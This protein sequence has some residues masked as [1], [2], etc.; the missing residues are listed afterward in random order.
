VAVGGVPAA[1]FVVALVGSTLLWVAVEG[2]TLRLKGTL[3][4]ATVVVAACGVLLIP[5]TSSSGSSVMAVVQGDV[6]HTR[7]LADMLR[8]TTVTDNHAALTRT[9]AAEVRAG[10]RG[11]PDVVVWPENSTDVDPADS[12]QVYAAIS[13]AVGAV[14][15]PVLVGAVLDAPHD[16]VYNAGQLWLPGRGPVETYVKRTLVPFGEYVPWRSLLAPHINLLSLVPHDFTPGT[17]PVVFP[18]GRTRLGDVICYEIAFDQLVRSDVRAGANVLVEQTNDATYERDGQTGE[19]EQQLQMA[20][21]RAIE[22]HRT[23]LV[24]ST[25]GVSA[26]IA[27]DGTVRARTGLWQPAL[28]DVTVPLQSD[29]TLADRVGAWPEAGICALTIGALLTACATR[30]RR[31]R[32]RSL[33][34]QG[35]PGAVEV[36]VARP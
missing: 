17:R 1:T 24:A 23:V 22:H 27:P 20:R 26:V 15:R 2:K 13:D 18:I 21:L 25:S 19:T 10:R 8:A 32:S 29:I 36:P 28:L 31:R 34:E 12:P 30:L 35:R 33:D 14:G 7:Q 16:H 5:R 6:P 9:L 11:R 4:G 3:A